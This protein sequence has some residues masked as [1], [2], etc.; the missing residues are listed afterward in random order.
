MK[1][2]V[3]L[4]FLC[5]ILLVSSCA[6]NIE[7]SGGIILQKNSFNIGE[8]ISINTI[9]EEEEILSVSIINNGNS[10]Q[11]YS[12]E[13]NTN[14]F[15]IPRFLNSNVN[16]NNQNIKLRVVT[17]KS[18]YTED[19]QINPSIIIQNL[20]ASENCNTVS[21]NVI[22]GVN[23]KLSVQSINTGFDRIEYSIYYF[24]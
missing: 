10:L 9:S 21:G 22:E 6:K 11:R 14:Y 1:K 13:N 2:I 7:E 17:N 19:L 18:V 3:N 15:V 5:I 24:E 16:L 23:N 12:V 20:C 4:L 8:S